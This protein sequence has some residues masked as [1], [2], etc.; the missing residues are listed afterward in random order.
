M[1]LP[2]DESV[3]HTCKHRLGCAKFLWQ[4]GRYPIVQLAEY[5][6]RC[7]HYPHAPDRASLAL[8]HSC[9]LLEMMCGVAL[10]LLLHLGC[11]I[12]ALVLVA[13]LSANVRHSDAHCTVDCA[14]RCPLKSMNAGSWCMNNLACQLAVVAVPFSHVRFR[15]IALAM[16]RA[17]ACQTRSNTGRMCR[18]N[19]RNETIVQ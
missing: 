10:P 5:I 7:F 9:S 4:W 2:D 19:K 14:R 1:C 12:C 6:K 18:N 11:T 8:F 17:K 15:G 3:R 13:M 16:V